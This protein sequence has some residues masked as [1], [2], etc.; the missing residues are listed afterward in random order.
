MH[1]RGLRGLLS[2]PVPSPD[3]CGYQPPVEVWHESRFCVR[4]L[5]GAS[6]WEGVVKTRENRETHGVA[7]GA[8]GWG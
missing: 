7:E 4:S 2:F 3:S 8:A 5:R 6:F 1:P